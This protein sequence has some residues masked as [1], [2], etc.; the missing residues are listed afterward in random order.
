M[1]QEAASYRQERSLTDRLSKQN[2]H[3]HQEED[4]PAAGMAAAGGELRVGA[5]RWPL[6][7]WSE[8]GQKASWPG[9]STLR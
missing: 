7:L 8:A 4:M 2:L 9:C 1:K 3:R 6:P 5:V